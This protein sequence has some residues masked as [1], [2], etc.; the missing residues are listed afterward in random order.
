MTSAA[1]RAATSLKKHR[2]V[3]KAEVVNGDCVK[4]ARTSGYAEVTV[5]V[6]NTHVDPSDLDRIGLDDVD[7][8]VTIGKNGTYSWDAKTEACNRG[9]DLYTNRELWTALNTKQF[10]GSESSDIQYF[11]ERIG[12]HD[13][14]RELKRVGRRLFRVH[15][16]GRLDTLLVYCA[17]EYILSEQFVHD[18]LADHRDVQVITNLSSWNKITAEASEEA[19]RRGCRVLDLSGVYGALYRDARSIRDV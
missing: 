1:E 9:R 13:K 8:I 17:D 2:R 18:V 19:K 14:V 15:R 4:I 12:S 16:T 7:A 10:V 3:S 5:R 6:V 11:V